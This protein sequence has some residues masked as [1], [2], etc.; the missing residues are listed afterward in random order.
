MSKETGERIKSNS[1]IGVR[2]GRKSGC[3]EHREAV[4]RKPCSSRAR[5]PLRNWKETLPGSPT[6]KQRCSQGALRTLT[7]GKESTRASLY[8][9]CYC[10]RLLSE[11][12]WQRSG[13]EGG[14]MKLL[15]GS[16]VWEGGALQNQAEMHS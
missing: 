2:T 3:R 4:G 15:P 8:S 1:W 5:I 14:R 13:S 10:K 16:V 9:N 6:P 7:P 12:L 11:L